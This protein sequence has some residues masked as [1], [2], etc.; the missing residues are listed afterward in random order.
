[1]SPHGFYEIQILEP[2]ERP[3]DRLQSQCD[4]ICNIG[5]TDGERKFRE[6]LF[7]RG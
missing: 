4:E 6:V 3:A 7:A 1:M 2:G 5:S